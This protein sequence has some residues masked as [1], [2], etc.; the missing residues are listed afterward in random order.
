MT[1]PEVRAA[2]ADA[3]V[4]HAFEVVADFLMK[5]ARVEIRD[6]GVFE[7]HRRKARKARNPRTGAR[8]DVPAKTVVKF[9]PAGALQRKAAQLPDVPQGE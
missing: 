3:G 9:K 1:A 8:I 5:E 2:L 7:L 4:Q 6:F